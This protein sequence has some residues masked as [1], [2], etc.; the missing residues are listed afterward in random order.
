MSE[1]MKA[2]VYHAPTKVAVESIPVPK[3]GADEL[4]VK[5]DA[6]AV[7]G[8]DLK[9]FQSGNPRIK[10]PMTMGHEFTG[11]IE[12][13]GAGVTGFAKG[14]RIV[15]A[16]S[17][18]CGDCL[19]CRRGWPNICA[20]IAPM[21]F[22]YHGGMAEYVI[23]PAQ[24]IKRGHVIKVPAKLKPEHAAL[25][26]PLSCTVNSCENSNIQR[27]DT[28]VVVGAGPMGIMNACMA[29]EYGAKTVF[30][31]EI[32]EA[33][34][35]QGAAFGCDRLINPAKEDLTKIVKDATGGL[36]A[37]VVV[38]AAPAGKPQEQALE[39][40]RRRGTVCLF[41][42]LSEGKHLI[43]LNSRLL[44]YGEL[45]V[46]GTSDSTPAHVQKAVDLMARGSM[47]LDKL[48]SHKLKLDEIHKAF[49]LMISGESLRVVL[50]P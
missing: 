39:L 37:D 49:E 1:T 42:S 11:L 24:A 20:K 15:M 46:V 5:V 22:S 25:A 30:L 2:V 29:R 9:A 45:R 21:G 27:G 34:L 43:T 12:T 48:A 44:H 19:Y 8:S 14:E 3:C 23:I 26:E 40:V 50:M 7:C 18:S 4:R 33:R 41:A 47:P 6:C 36:G 13:V 32:N 28:V 10:P 16:T 31:A 17:V 38:V 35:K